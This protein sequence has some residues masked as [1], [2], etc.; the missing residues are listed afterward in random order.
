MEREQKRE[1]PKNITKQSTP[2]IDIPPCA[3]RFSDVFFGIFVQ[4]AQTLS[5]AGFYFGRGP[6]TCVGLSD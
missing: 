2:F 5:T 4:P 1:E 3:V 6:C